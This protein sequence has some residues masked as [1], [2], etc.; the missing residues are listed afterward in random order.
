MTFKD[1][2]AY[3]DVYYDKIDQ[4]T[5]SLQH[6]DRRPMTSASTSPPPRRTSEHNSVH[7]LNILFTWQKQILSWELDWDCTADDAAIE[8]AAIVEVHK[9]FFGEVRADQPARPD[10]LRVPETRQEQLMLELE[11]MKQNWTTMSEDTREAVDLPSMGDAAFGA[12]MD[13]LVTEEGTATVGDGAT[14]PA[15]D[16]TAT[17]DAADGSTGSDGG[18]PATPGQPATAAEQQQHKHLQYQEELL[19]EVLN[20]LQPPAQPADL[21]AEWTATA[22]EYL[23]KLGELSV[24][25]EDAITNQLRQQAFNAT[26]A[27]YENYF[28]ALETHPRLLVGNPG[29]GHRQGRDGDSEGQQ[30]CEGMAGG[31]S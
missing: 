2:P 4:L 25:L 31:R 21:P 15:A 23:P 3:R 30:R 10:Q 26:R 11:E 13:A 28:Q 22:D 14:P 12:L 27:E 29:A 19:K 24:K 20:S 5:E 9:M 17:A 7:Y 6:R 8:L 18:S 16:A 1:M